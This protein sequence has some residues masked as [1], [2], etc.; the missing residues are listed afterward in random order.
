ML[1]AP[2]DNIPPPRPP[3]I[4]LKNIRS[5]GNI[6]LV[7]FFKN[8]TGWIKCNYALARKRFTEVRHANSVVLCGSFAIYCWARWD[9]KCWSDQFTMSAVFESHPVVHAGLELQYN[10]GRPQT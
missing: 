2:R 3:Y 7:Y 1:A 9:A 6:C 10:S 4:V 5:R 8:K